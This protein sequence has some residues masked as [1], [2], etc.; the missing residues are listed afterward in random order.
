[1]RKV[2]RNTDEVFHCWAHSVQPQGESGNV[3]FVGGIVFT[4]AEPIGYL[5]ESGGAALIR[6]LGW[7]ITSSR[8]VSQARRALPS[9]IKTIDVVA[10]PR[11][12]KIGNEEHRRNRA[13]FEQEIGKLALWIK[14]PRR[15][16]SQIVNLSMLS[17]LIEAHNDYARVFGLDWPVLTEGEDTESL[18]RQLAEHRAAEAAREEAARQKRIREEQVVL[19]E[20]RAGNDPNRMFETVALRVNEVSSEIEAT[21]GARIPLEDAIK[22]WPLLC[23]AKRAGGVE[24]D[25]FIRRLGHYR[26]DRFDGETLT[27]GCHEIPWSELEMIAASLGLPAY[28][29]VKEAA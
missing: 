4:Y 6:N 28:E 12:G 22:V 8:H 13:H 29:P 26:I 2:L 27:V 24:G 10:L 7:S 17:G 1:M 14:E 21:R 20:W 25:I 5:T 23:R 16:R 3:S 9:Y 18:G 19:A 15:K 11:Y